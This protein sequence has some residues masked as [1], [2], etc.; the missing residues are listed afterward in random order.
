ML[1]GCD[2]PAQTGLGGQIRFRAAS[3]SMDTR[4][5]YSGDTGTE[6]SVTKERINWIEGDQVT[7]WSDKAVY[8]GDASRRTADYKVKNVTTS[9]VRSIAELVAT[10]ANGFQWGDEAAGTNY[11][12]Y[13]RYPADQT[14]INGTNMTAEI[15]ATQTLLY[16]S[17]SGKISPDMK[18]A[19]MFASTTAPIHADAVKLEFDPEFTA[20]EFVVGG[21][22]NGQVNLTSFKLSSTSVPV[23][24]GFQVVC[25][26]KAATATG[27]AANSV[28]MDFSNLPGG[29]LTVTG[30]TPVTVTVF[31]VPVELKNL[32]L[33]VTGDKIQ[34]RT[35]KLNNKNGSTITFAGG[36][37][38]RITGL[39]LPELLNVNG[40]DI[41]WDIEALL[42]PMVW[43]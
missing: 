13:A 39:N 17:E 34:T 43:D 24:G 11:T 21:G 4:T 10:D 7:V 23:S 31:A 2:K 38:Y 36:R 32:T 35:L 9:G 12:F 5:A 20:L 16:D 25:A 3:G 26:S 40:K 18:Y 19:F 41:D 1:A 28:S 14:K 27:T 8:L 42:E 6:G 15:P 22:G 30:D 29:K 33:E 37:K